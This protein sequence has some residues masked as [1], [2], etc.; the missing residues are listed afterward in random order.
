MSCDFFD[1]LLITLLSWL[2]MDAVYI[3]LVSWID[4]IR[5]S[6]Q[7]VCI[8]N[9]LLLSILDGS[10]RFKFNA[11]SGDLFAKSPRGQI[12]SL[13]GQIESNRIAALSNR[14]P[15]R[16]NRIS[17]GVK[18]RFKSSRDF[19]FAHHWT[20]DYCQGTSSAVASLIYSSIN[21]YECY[22]FLNLLSS[23]WRCWSDTY[24]LEC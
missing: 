21:R 2:V 22:A 13:K 18:S 5:L 23:S 6:I 16:S 8:Q 11:Y 10:G 3:C 15:Q 9:N 7:H 24:G 20:I 19:D 12:E 14:I 1:K 17:N 4:T